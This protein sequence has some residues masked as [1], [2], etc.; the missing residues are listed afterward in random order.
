MLA[1]LRE[2]IDPNEYAIEEYSDVFAQGVLECGAIQS[3]IG[4][5][6]RR[7]ILIPA[8]EDG[9]T[10]VREKAGKLTSA[11]NNLQSIARLISLIAG[12]IAGL[13]SQAY[14]NT[15]LEGAGL[16]ER[17]AD[18]R[19]SLL[20]LLSHLKS[21]RPQYL[22]N[23]LK[24]LGLS[25][26]SQGLRLNIGSGTSPLPRPWVNVDFPGKGD[27]AMNV[28]WG[29]PFAAGA[30]DYIYASHFFEHINY[31]SGALDLLRDF[32]RAMAEGGRLRLAAPN[33]GGM[34]SAYSSGKKTFFEEREKV[35][36]ETKL[37]CKTPLEHI[38]E[39][40][41]TGIRSRPGRFFDHKFGY[42]YETL[43]S[44]LRDVGFAEIRQCAYMQSPDPVLRIDNAG[45]VT[46][47]VLDGIPNTLF[48]ECVKLSAGGK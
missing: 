35:F 33:I 27:L 9:A 45:V 10:V 17:L 8:G 38:L 39:Y 4:D 6:A 41:G 16:F 3:I 36:Q 29:L 13:G 12:E 47:S 15:A 24:L 48:V 20:E 11:H 5:L 14:M 19:H 22:E 31:K 28:L 2:P 21:L 42:D 37:L 34:I 1:F 30:V 23:Q 40:A 25:A 46:E 7:E 18:A 44:L 32:H 26:E 43:G